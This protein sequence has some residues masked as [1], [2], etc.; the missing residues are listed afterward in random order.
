[1][2]TVPRA[3]GEE[4]L[5]TH[6]RPHGTAIASRSTAGD[7]LADGALGNK[8]GLPLPRPNALG[9]GRPTVPSD[10]IC[11]RPDFVRGGHPSSPARHCHMWRLWSHRIHQRDFYGITTCRDAASGGR[12]SGRRAFARGTDSV[13]A[14]GPARHWSGRSIIHYAARVLSH[15]RRA[16][17]TDAHVPHHAEGLVPV[18]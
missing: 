2:T 13:L 5:P 4:Y 14:H 7:Q 17:R 1:M 15:Y 16:N 6:A 10:L 11:A 8:P 9:C 18:A 12:A 3:A